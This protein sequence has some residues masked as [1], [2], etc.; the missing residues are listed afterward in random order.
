MRHEANI[1]EAQHA[2]NALSEADMK[3]L[4]INADQFELQAIAEAAAVQARIAVEILMEHGQPQW[5]LDAD[6]FAGTNGGFRPRGR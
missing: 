1:A 6:R 5:K 3:T 2:A 4:E